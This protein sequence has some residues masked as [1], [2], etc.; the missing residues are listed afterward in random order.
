[1]KNSINTE[2]EQLI[3]V[4]G[5]TGLQGRAV[6]RNLLQKGF[7]VRAL[8][9]NPDQEAAQT[10]VDR[11]AEIVE[12]NFE[13][14]SSLIRAMENVY[15]AFSVQPIQFGNP[16]SKENEIKWGKALVD[17][18]LAANVEHFVYS[19]AAGADHKTGVPHFD[20]KWEIEN[21][22]RETNLPWTILYPVAF[23]EDWELFFKEPILNGQIPM[24]LSPDTKFQQIA[25]NDI[26]AFATLA[27]SNPE[28]WKGQAIQVAGDEQMMTEI[29]EYF[30]EVRSDKVEYVQVP[31]Q[32]FEEQAGK[33]MTKMFHYVEE[34]GWDAN[35][36]ALHEK[37]FEP[38][39]FGPFIREQH[40]VQNQTQIV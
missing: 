17:A 29:A 11:G 26:G 8:T 23:M 7:N 28:E 30:S 32:A 37:Y 39:K 24:P 22:I 3:L 36:E 1:M 35:I 20:S 12:G 19:S 5:A 18:A 9:R 33:E 2:D 16:K 27:F 34:T 13:D 31:W 10:L 14:R 6:A 15:G 4:S 38:K 21:Y 25:V 40:W